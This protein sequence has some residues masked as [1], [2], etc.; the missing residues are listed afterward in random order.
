MNSIESGY[1]KTIK[2]RDTVS[3]KMILCQSPMKFD[4]KYIRSLE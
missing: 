3:H 2:K 4:D 1:L